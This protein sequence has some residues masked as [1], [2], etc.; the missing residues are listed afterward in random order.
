MIII[1]IIN[2]HILISIHYHV[3]GVNWSSLLHTLETA[4]NH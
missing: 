1:C 4:A 3:E 2:Y